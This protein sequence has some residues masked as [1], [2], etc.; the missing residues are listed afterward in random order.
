MFVNVDEK[1]VRFG[2]QSFI[3]MQVGVIRQM[4]SGVGGGGHVTKKM[5][6]LFRS[7]SNVFPTHTY[8]FNECQRRDMLIKTWFTFNR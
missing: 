4:D 2:E 8:F 3:I 1:E 7:G 5:Q 6:L